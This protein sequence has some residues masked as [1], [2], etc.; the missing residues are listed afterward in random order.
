MA[1]LFTIN[2]RDVRLKGKSAQNQ[3]KKAGKKEERG[4]KKKRIGL[5]VPANSGRE[6]PSSRKVLNFR[7]KTYY[8]IIMGGRRLPSRR[9]A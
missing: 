9:L 3:G 6:K 2:K 4:R 7:Q 8:R 1:N 5:K